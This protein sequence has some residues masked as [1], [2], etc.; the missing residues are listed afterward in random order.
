M[1]T[2]QRRAHT[3]NGHHVRAH[4]THYRAGAQQDSS[5]RTYM[6]RAELLPDLALSGLLGAI[7][8][9][10]AQV[11]LLTAVAILTALVSALMAFIGRTAYHSTSRGRQGASRRKRRGPIHRRVRAYASRKARLKWARYQRGRHAK[12][13]AR[14]Q[15][16]ERAQR[17]EQQVVRERSFGRRKRDTSGDEAKAE[18]I[19]AEAYRRSSNKVMSTGDKVYADR[20]SKAADAAGANGSATDFMEAWLRLGRRN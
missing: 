10:L 3:R 17:L 11:F 12:K 15:G 14:R 20:Y 8:Y 18:G 1:A 5:S 4:T 2:T 13:R 19:K 9:G 7:V 6:S 16:T